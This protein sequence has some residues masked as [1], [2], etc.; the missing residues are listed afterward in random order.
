VAGLR[1]VETL[2]RFDLPLTLK[3]VT[4]LEAELPLVLKVARAIEVQLPSESE[5]VV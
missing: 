1:G 2:L 5:V 4:A 3:A